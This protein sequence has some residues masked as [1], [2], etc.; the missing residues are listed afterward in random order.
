MSRIHRAR[1]PADREGRLTWTSSGTE[2]AVAVPLPNPASLAPSPAAA[3]ARTLTPPAWERTQP[4]EEPAAWGPAGQP[5]SDAQL[6]PMFVAAVAP[7]S[8]A[9]EHYRMLR[10]RLERQEKGRRTQIVMVT[11]SLAG[12]GKTTTS[13]NLALT[14]GR[15]FGQRV[16]LIEGDLRRPT[17]AELFGLPSGP[18]LVDVIVGA[19]SLESALV[20][21][22]AHGIHVLPGGLPTARSAGLV[23]STGLQRAIDSLRR[24]FDRIILDAPP[25]NVA[26]THELARIADGVLFVVRS[27]VTPRGAVERALDQLDADKLLGVV[28][29]DTPLPSDEAGY[30]VATRDEARA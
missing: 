2:A 29:N 1:E 5:A 20:E 21:V 30:S 19:A 12:D 27:G 10:S 16:V 7:S 22:P 18:G 25:A 24:R 6:S 15:E 11:S 14:M 28:M 9:A 17:L 4:E 3:P 13:A 26:D 23:A 8:A